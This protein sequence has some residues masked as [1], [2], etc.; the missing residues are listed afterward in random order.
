MSCWRTT[1][2]LISSMW[3]TTF[4]RWTRNNYACKFSANI[5]YLKLY[6]ERLGTLPVLK[7]TPPF[8]FSQPLSSKMFQNSPFLIL[9]WNIE[10]QWWMCHRLWSEIWSKMCLSFHIFRWICLLPKLT[11]M[12]G[13]GIGL[14]VPSLFSD[15]YFSMK[16]KNYY[17]SKKRR[18]RTF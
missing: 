3:Y 2:W 12:M 15:S 4:W 16:N 13:E 7:R 6:T 9:K 8:V 11:L 10:N 18:M 17:C 5:C 14:T 1:P